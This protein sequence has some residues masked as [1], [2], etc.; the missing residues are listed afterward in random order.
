MALRV[1]W[2]E[3]ADV[4]PLTPLVVASVVAHLV[5]AVF[6]FLAPHILPSRPP[7]GPILVVDL[8]SLP[9][10]GAGALQEPRATPPPP[11]RKA[12]PKPAPEPKAKAKTKPPK[13]AAIKLPEPGKKA[14]AKAE[15]PEPTPKEPEAPAPAAG[16][17][18]PGA[19][20]ESG[21][22]PGIGGEGKPGFGEQKDGGIGA[23]DAETFEFAWYKAALTQKLR[24]SWSK[25]TV[26]GLAAQIRCVVH[27]KVLR[28]GRIIDID[29]E[30][31]SGLD[32][33]DRSALRAVYD[34]NPLPP[35]PYGFKEE[36]LGV[37][38]FFELVPE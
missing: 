31:T 29:L 9:P 36:S 14:P 28:N 18:P 25:P 15:K 22:A 37:H 8:V 16:V 23:L 26:P 3:P 11:S 20:S 32:L 34:A 27:F 19:S 33:L 17:T 30:N 7:A 12:E 2:R 35:L 38:F 13:P 1:E 5:A 21:P 4:T 6:G 10:G 24:N